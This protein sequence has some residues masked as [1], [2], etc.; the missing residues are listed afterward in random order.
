M[1][2]LMDKYGPQLTSF[3]AFVMLHFVTLGYK[4]VKLL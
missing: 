1:N 4:E 3:A 2:E